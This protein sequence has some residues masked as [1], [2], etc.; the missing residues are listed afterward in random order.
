MR[1]EY[2]YRNF[3]LFFFISLF[4]LSKSAIADNKALPLDNRCTDLNVKVGFVDGNGNG[5][6]DITG[7]SIGTTFKL[8]TLEGSSGMCNGDY[9]IDNQG[10]GF[11]MVQTG[12][13][14]VNAPV[15]SSIPKTRISIPDSNGMVGLMS[16]ATREHG[17]YAPVEEGVQHVM[18][19]EK[20]PGV[21][22]ISITELLGA[23][24]GNIW[25]SY[26][27]FD[28]HNGYE[29]NAKVTYG[30]GSIKLIYRPT[31]T[32]SVNDVSFGT[33]TVDEI[34]QGN[35]SGEAIVEVSC[36]DILLNYDIKISSNY[37]SAL[38][39]KGII[40]SNN[41]TIEYQLNW[42]DLTG[43]GL[44]GYSNSGINLDAT[45][46]LRVNDSPAANR[47]LIP[48]KVT[49]TPNTAPGGDIKPGEANSDIVIQMTFK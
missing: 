29:S 47:F 48:I 32:I 7:V 19:I 40:S 15:L 9:G 33:L 12:R 21:T 34:S 13:T 41:E 22:E 24:N 28:W 17:P 10:G 20:W 18:L 5:E 2:Y 16:F 49:P 44:D 42:G 38:A 30:R 35:K 4:L 45:Y 6:I 14:P 1:V 8:L 25:T 43:S 3:S 36:N 26:N 39:G 37:K 27:R 11:V 31:C 23:V 46:S